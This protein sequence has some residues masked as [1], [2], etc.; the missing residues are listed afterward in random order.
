MRIPLNVKQTMRRLTYAFHKKIEMTTL[1]REQPGFL[2]QTTSVVEEEF[3]GACAA[4]M[5]V[6][7]ATWISRGFGRS[8]NGGVGINRRGL[9]A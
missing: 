6:A 3:E 2:V 8:W 1:T 7:S 4:L 5:R 9:R